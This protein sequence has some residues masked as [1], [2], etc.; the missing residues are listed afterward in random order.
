VLSV[1][2][3]LANDASSIAIPVES[4]FPVTGQVIMT[5]PTVVLPLDRPSADPKPIEI[6]CAKFCAPLV[7]PEQS[8]I[9]VERCEVELLGG[10]AEHQLRE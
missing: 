6:R 8:T 9:V 7:F 3:A 2:V 5:V 4:G 10:G 1:S